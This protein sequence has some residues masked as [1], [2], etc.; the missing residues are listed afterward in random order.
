MDARNDLALP[1]RRAA[2]RWNENPTANW[3]LFSRA[4]QRSGTH[5]VRGMEQARIVQSG[6][7]CRSRSD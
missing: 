3:S 2:R 5:R 7:G 4:F 6:G 1:R